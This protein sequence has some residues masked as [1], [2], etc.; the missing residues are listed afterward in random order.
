MTTAPT[1]SHHYPRVFNLDAIRPPRDFV[2]PTFQ[3]M[4]IAFE[5]GAGK[6]KHAVLFATQNPT[7][8]LYALER[9]REKAHAHLKKGE[10]LPNLQFIHSDAIA[11]AVYALPPKSLSQVF[12]LYPN[13]E[14]KN[15]N[16]RFVNMPFF[17]FLLSR[18]ADGARLTLASN[19]ESYIDEVCD[20]LDAVWCVPFSRAKV[21]ASS[22][23]TH[24][25]V[26]YLA[27]GE[28]CEEVVLTKPVGY[29]TRFDE[30]PA[31]ELV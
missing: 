8:Q 27:R 9:T 20:A 5:I 31:K 23:R 24:F 6:G 13:P 12:V 29:R 14:P 11:W 1:L 10:I 7:V 18:M 4:P 15:R 30:T 2:A 17:E 26:K 3:D 16:Q 22:A 21:P 25:E 28:C 19:I